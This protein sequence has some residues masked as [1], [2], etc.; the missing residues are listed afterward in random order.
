[1][2]I[3]PASRSAEVMSA[4]AV[5]LGLGV[6]AGGAL[7]TTGLA[8]SDAYAHG[9]AG[10]FDNASCTGVFGIVASGEP[11]NDGE[12]GGPHVVRSVSRLQGLNDGRDE[13]LSFELGD[14]RLFT[15]SLHC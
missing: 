10:R 14:P 8:V 6:K 7:V 3:T 15:T 13:R 12:S 1:M 11:T 2:S 4:A 9:L 5:N